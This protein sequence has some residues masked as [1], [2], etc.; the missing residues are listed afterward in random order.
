MLCLALFLSVKFK[1]VHKKIK[2]QIFEN[3]YIFNAILGKLPPFGKR[4]IHAKAFKPFNCDKTK[5]N[6]VLFLHSFGL[7]TV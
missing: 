4:N 6:F 1:C 7:I 2:I 3:M 5:E